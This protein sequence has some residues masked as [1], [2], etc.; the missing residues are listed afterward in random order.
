MRRSIREQRDLI[1][2]HWTA[3]GDAECDPFYQVGEL[4]R[5]K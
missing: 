1:G 3:E 4:T 2:L 5:F